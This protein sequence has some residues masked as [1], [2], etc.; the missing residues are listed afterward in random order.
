MVEATLK[1]G[2]QFTNWRRSIAKIWRAVGLETVD[3]DFSRRVQIPA[4]IGPKRFHVAVVALGFAAKELVAPVR[5]RLVET[6]WRWLRRRDGELIE[7]KRLQLG[8]DEIV[9]R[10]DV[11][12]ITKSVG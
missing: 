5:R 12:E 8:R 9:I 4:R 10:T 7:L 2:E 1:V 11:G 3:A 6:T